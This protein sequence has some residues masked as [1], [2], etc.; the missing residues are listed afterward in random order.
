MRLVGRQCGDAGRPEGERIDDAFGVHSEVGKLRKVIVHRPDL[1][2]KRLTPT[3][4]DD[5]LFDDVL[6]VERAQWEHDQFVARMRE[7][8]VEVLYVQ[9]LLAEALAA[10]DEARLRLIE[11]V[12]SAAV[13]GPTLVDAVGEALSALAPDELAQHLIGGLTVGRIRA[14]S[15]PRSRSRRSSPRRSTTTRPSSCRRCRTRCSRATRR[16]GSTTASRSTRCTGR[17]GGARPT[18]WPRSIAPTR[19]S[20]TQSFEFWYPTLGEDDRFRIEDFGRASL[21]GGDVEI[22]GRGTVAIGMSER[23]TGRMIEQI[24]LALFEKG[25]AERVIAAVMTKDRAH[26]HLDTVFT[27]LDRDKATAYPKVVSG[28]RSISLRPG[29][30]SRAR[31]TFARTRTSCRRSTTR[32][33]PSCTS[34]RRA[35]TRTSRR[36]SS[37]TTATTSSRWSPASSSPTSA[38]RSPS[39]RCAR[40]ASRSSRSPASSSARVAVAATA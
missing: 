25:A 29:K 33:A 17:P 20:R 31:S 18:T 7:R 23:T 6:W 21:E 27:L 14:R 28:I 12:A 13:V 1:S 32:W 4:H 24:A 34:S 11:L 36:A 38:T 16:A 15:R 8:G 5:L 2:L 30:T 39:R 19:C 35:A 10:S 37:G 9:D 22:I 40:P 3:N 26:M